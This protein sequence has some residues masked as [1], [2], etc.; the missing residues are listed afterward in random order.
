[1]SL[2]LYQKQ[3]AGFLKASADDITPPPVTAGHLKGISMAERAGIYKNNVYVALI[4][5]L[6]ATYPAT[7]R[8]VGDEFFVFTARQYLE[9]HWPDSPVLHRFG[10]SFS[11]F[12]ETFGPAASVPYLKDVARLEW[13]YLQ[14]FHAAEA[15]PLPAQALDTV[16]ADGKTHLAL[17]PSSRLMT[18]DFPVS[19][20]WEI[21]RTDDPIEPGTSLGN[22][23]EYLLIIR[24]DTR[25]EV[26]RLRLST[27]MMV[28]CIVH[29]APLS[30]AFDAAY[31]ADKDSNPKADLYDLA[32]G[33]TFID[34]RRRHQHE[35]TTD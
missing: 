13:L 19:R 28:H 22:G 32:H 7:L 10:G 16:I 20:I 27:Y 23:A 12:L 17:H 11:T 33:K 8:L 15:H 26:R 3:F 4:D 34:P 5:A 6:K 14:A 2:D 1:M 35:Q 9:K 21:N 30:T 24:P 29:G 25:V 31:D 18:S